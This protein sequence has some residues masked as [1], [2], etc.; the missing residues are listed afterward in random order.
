MILQVTEQIANVRFTAASYLKN[1]DA[2]ST[3]SRNK[4]D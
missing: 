3:I 1:A 4:F 2:R